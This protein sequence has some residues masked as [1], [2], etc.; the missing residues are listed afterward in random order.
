[1]EGAYRYFIIFCPFSGGIWLL[2]FKEQMGM[3]TIH[4]SKDLLDRIEKL[5]KQLNGIINRKQ[6]LI[7]S[8]ILAASRRLD[9]LIN[10]YNKFVVINKK[11]GA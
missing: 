3:I 4:N 5:R 7:D 2:V 11:S 10:E 6:V 8:E 1:M 9:T